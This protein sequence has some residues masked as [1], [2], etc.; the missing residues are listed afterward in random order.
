M[1][2]ELVFRVSL[3]VFDWGAGAGCVRGRF[4][5]V[6]FHQAFHSFQDIWNASTDSFQMLEVGMYALSLLL[7]HHLIHGMTWSS[8][9][10]ISGSTVA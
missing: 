6:L 10:C 9:M 4:Y 1:G 2:W 3:F 5:I 8:K 7:F